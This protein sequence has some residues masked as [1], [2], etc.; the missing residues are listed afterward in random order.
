MGQLGQF[1][2]NHWELWLA[3]VVVLALIYINELFTQKKRAAE[4]SPQAAVHMINNESAIVIDLRDTDS[5]RSGHI[6]DAI[7]ASVDDFNQQRMD[8]YKDKP[9]IFVC[10]K[11]LQSA[12]LATKLKQEGF[13]QPMVLAGGIAAWQ[14]AELPLIKGK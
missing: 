6:I 8:K 13:K 14:N 1:I 4:L 2:M 3:L 12:P 5:F 9:L 7:R 11:G 10:P